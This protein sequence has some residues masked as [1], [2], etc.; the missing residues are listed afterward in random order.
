MSAA[1]STTE[2]RAMSRYYTVLDLVARIIKGARFSPEQSTVDIITAGRIAGISPFY[3][4]E[5]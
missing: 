1:H 5:A 3:G 2:A 4:R